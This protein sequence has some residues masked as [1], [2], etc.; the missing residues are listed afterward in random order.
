[1]KIN[2]IAHLTGHRGAVYTLAQGNT[3]QYITSAGGDGWVVLWD[4]DK[5]DLGRVIAKVETRIF[6]ICVAENRIIAGN[7]DGGIH[8]INLDNP[9]LTKNIQHHQKGVFDIQIMGNQVYTIGGEGIITRWDLDKAQSIE[10]LHL[11]SKSLRCMDYC[12]MRAEI[13]VGSSDGHIYI[14]D[15]NFNIKYTIKN[16]H[17]NS[18]FA[19]KYTPDGQY[20]LSGGR[21]A[22]LNIWDLKDMQRLYEP[23][24]AH[25][26]TINDIAFH[27][28]QKEIFATASRDKTIKI[29]SFEPHTEGGIV[30]KKVINTIRNGGHIHSVNKL[31]W[32]TH[33]EYLISGSD[34]QS[35]II[36]K[37]LTYN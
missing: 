11:S 18:V 37:E 10:S 7:M 22:E 12:P 4:L 23:I 2:K 26:F 21:D 20:I 24:P 35:L 27:P 28:I 17:K 6:S 9:D 33:H 15:K 16:A 3:P 19:I 1:L 29:W 36:W 13:A 8:F 34:D 5:P 30:L 14:L 31:L 32:S 25:N